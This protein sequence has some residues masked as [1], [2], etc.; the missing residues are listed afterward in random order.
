MKQIILLTG[1]TANGKSKL[2]RELKERHGFKIFK[3]SHHIKKEAE[4]RGLDTNRQGLKDLGD[5]L[6]NETNHRWIL[7][8]VKEFIKVEE[9]DST[10]VVDSIRKSEQLELFRRQ[11]E[12][13]VT[14][15]HLYASSDVLEKRF[16]KREGQ[17]H[18]PLDANGN[19]EIDLIK[20]EEDIQAFKTDAD[21]R[22]NTDRTDVI[23]TRTRVEAYLGLFSDPDRKCVDVLIGGQYGSEGKGQVAA[24]LAQEYDVLV[25]VGGPNAGH[26]AARETGKYTYHSLP[27]GC[28]ESEADILIGPGA[29]I[30]MG[31]FFKEVEECGVD[32]ERIYLDPNVMVITDADREAE[33]GLKNSIGSTGRGGGSA[34]SRRIMGRFNDERKAKLACDYEELEPF[35]K[36]THDR[37][38]KAYAS[39]EKILLEGTQGALLSLYH[40]PYPYVT[41]RDTNVAGCLSEA[42]IPPRRV[43]RV[44]MVVRFTPI[45]VQS[46]KAGNSGK[47]KHETNFEKIRAEAKIPEDLQVNEKT[48]TTKLNRRVGWFEW[49]QFRFACELN[50]PTDIIL[51]FADYQHVKNRDA[52]R[53]EQLD[54]DTIKFVEELERVAQ[55]PVSLINTRYPH[56]EETP[57]DLRT[58]IDRRHWRAKTR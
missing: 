3:T 35:V 32:A 11:L 1:H 13:E 47:L 2:A 15:V 22:I 8:A 52:R 29:T 50:A 14:H 51:T 56:D 57:L 27:S 31:E 45:R 30:H 9:P 17:D 33:G 12:L 43:D 16:R 10:I 6:D 20:S 7:D 37:L 46:P 34:A 53:F 19:A 24:Y 44:M 54:D 5:T 49:E 38:I 28:R 41:A 42:G 40:G 36:S 58:L 25:R 55:A 39:G 4:R 18:I 26:Q 23:D 21:V 48:S